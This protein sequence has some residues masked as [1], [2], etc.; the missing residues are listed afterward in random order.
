[1]AQKAGGFFRVPVMEREPRFAAA[2]VASLRRRWL[3]CGEPKA[4]DFRLSGSLRQRD[5]SL[6]Q[7]ALSRRR[8]SSQR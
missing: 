7:S 4:F 5:P 6:Q 2:K 1:M 8:G 3:R